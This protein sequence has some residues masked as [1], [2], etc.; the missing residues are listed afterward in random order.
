MRIPSLAP[1]PERLSL[2]LPSGRVRL[3][4]YRAH[5]RGRTLAAYAIRSA[6]TASGWR[7][8]GLRPSALA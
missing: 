7:L 4:L 8:V 6:S 2:L 5:V 3:E 1:M